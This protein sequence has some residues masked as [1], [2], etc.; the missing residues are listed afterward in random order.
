MTKFQDTNL[1]IKHK[2]TLKNLHQ[3]Y[4]SVWRREVLIITSQVTQKFHYC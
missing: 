1:P 3:C 2:L 4:G